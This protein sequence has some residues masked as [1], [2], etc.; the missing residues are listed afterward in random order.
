ME[1]DR[2]PLVSTAACWFR[3]MTTRSGGTWLRLALL[4]LLTAV[5]PAVAQPPSLFLE[6]LTSPELRTL[7]REGWTVA[8]VPTGGT[9]QNGAHLP[10]GK[11]NLVVRRTAEEIARRLG[12]AVVAPVIAHVPEGAAEPPEGHMRF[13]GT[14]TLP[15][16]VFEAVLEETARS[17]RAH[18]FRLICFLGD[19]GGSQAAQRR[20]AERL[21]R[22]WG[23]TGTRVLHL[24]AYYAMQRQT[25]ALRAKGFDAGSIGSHAAL[26]DT[27]EL[28]AVAP[29]AVR[30]DALAAGTR[31]QGGD[32]DPSLASVELGAAMLELKETAAV[33]QIRAFLAQAAR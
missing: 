10:L 7:I 15:E 14:L 25:E 4:F 20:V 29:E 26:A 28:M 31:G 17:L 23:K 32:G 22:A 21:D 3:D 18:G 27:A 24:G 1:F 12:N 5:T 9:E 6:E 30:R 16:P 33:E 8:L 11:H 13:A 19:H 2:L